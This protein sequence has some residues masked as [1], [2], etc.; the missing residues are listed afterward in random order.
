[1]FQVGLEARRLDPLARTI[2]ENQLNIIVGSCFNNDGAKY[3]MFFLEKLCELL[4]AKLDVS[5]LDFVYV[6]DQSN[7]AGNRK[8]DE[9]ILDEMLAK[10]FTNP[11]HA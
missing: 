2:V 5:P 6:V 1:M 9:K 8:I 7:S 4:Q 11:E 10:S 3:R